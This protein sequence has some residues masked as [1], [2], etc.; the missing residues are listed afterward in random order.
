MSHLGF[1]EDNEPE[2]KHKGVDLFAQVDRRLIETIRRI[3]VSLTGFWGSIATP[4]LASN[5]SLIE[6]ITGEPLPWRM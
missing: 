2:T 5:S 3:A 6:N 4:K 1:D